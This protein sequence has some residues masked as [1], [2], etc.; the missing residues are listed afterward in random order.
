MIIKT[1]EPNID[2]CSLHVLT[3]NLDTKRKNC[4]QNFKFS[5]FSIC[6][7][8]IICNI[9]PLQ[10]QI[11]DGAALPSS[12]VTSATARNID[13]PVD[14]STGRATVQIPLCMAGPSNMQ[15]PLTL[16]YQT[17]G[18]KVTDIATWVGLGWDLSAG[19][20]ITRVVRGYPDEKGYL[21]PGMNTSL[22]FLLDVQKNWDYGIFDSYY[23]KQSKE[24]LDGQPDVFYD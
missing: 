24:Y 13:I 20:K 23:D 9:I 5:R 11:T 17:S 15:I 6:F 2:H 7:F 14:L 3:L 18:I 16:S 1:H 10:A 21:V 19:G 22:Q 4:L 12:A 8:L